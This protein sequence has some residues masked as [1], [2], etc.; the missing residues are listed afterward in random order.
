MSTVD[1]CTN[2]EYNPIYELR[3]QSTIL[4]GSKK[5]RILK[6]LFVICILSFSTSLFAL[7]HIIQPDP[8]AGKDT[9]VSMSNPTS[10]HGNE[11][12]MWV[13][14]KTWSGYEQ[15]Y[16]LMQFGIPDNL[17]DVTITNATFEFFVTRTFFESS[18]VA[19]AHKIITSWDESS[20]N[21]NSKPDFETTPF[22]SVSLLSNVDPNPAFSS[23]QP[24]WAQIDITST[25]QN[26]ADGTWENYGL[27]L[28]TTGT[29]NDKFQFYSSDYTNGSLRPKITVEYTATVPEP[30]IFLLFLMGLGTII[31]KQKK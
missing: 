31:R 21:W 14:R 27:L 1:T 29:I 24:Y 13:I 30:S 26:W 8:V 23:T 12:D 10:T 5:M 16:S 7:T 15:Q 6:I 2:Y 19:S 4:I 3:T 18:N 11:P 17:T 9:V 20:V 22:G 25:F 28:K